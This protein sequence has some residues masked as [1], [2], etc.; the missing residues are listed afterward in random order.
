VVGVALGIGSARVIAELASW[1]TLVSLPT[2]VGSILFSSV[3]GIAFGFYPA[4][5]AA[6]LDPIA[7]L[8]Y[9]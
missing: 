2:A 6:R 8:R 7:A 1:P 5:K 9:E 3:V 4:R